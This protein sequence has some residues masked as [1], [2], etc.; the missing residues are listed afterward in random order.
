MFL[1]ALIS[2]IS[3]LPFLSQSLKVVVKEEKIVTKTGDKIEMI[4]S[5][6]SEKV[7]CSFT[8]PAGQLLISLTCSNVSNRREH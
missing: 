1:G 4:C 2:L 8:S 3:T 5:S 6:V 7:G